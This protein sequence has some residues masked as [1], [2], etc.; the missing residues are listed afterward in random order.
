MGA[1][2]EAPS[3]HPALTWENHGAPEQLGLCN[4]LVSRGVCSLHSD[5]HD[6]VGV[7]ER[8]PRASAWMRTRGLSVPESGSYSPTC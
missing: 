2:W 8:R 6:V 3:T 1:F 5:W 4:H 7:L